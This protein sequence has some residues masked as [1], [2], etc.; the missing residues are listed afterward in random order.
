MYESLDTLKIKEKAGIASAALELKYRKAHRME[1]PLKGLQGA[2]IFLIQTKE[3][4][5]KL[6]ALS[7]LYQKV[8]SDKKVKDIILLDA[9]HSATIEGA[10]TTVENVKR[11][12]D[13]PVSKD[14][15]MV[16]NTI[17]GINYAYENQI[18]MDNIRTL[19]EIITQDVCENVHLAGAQFRSGMV[20]V[21]S[22]TDIIHTPAK[23]EEISTMM[24]DLFA[25]IE[26]SELN[27]WMKAAIIHF[28]FVYIH[29]FCDGN[30][31]TAR[32]MTQSF[33]LHHGIEKIK[34]LP[35]SRTINDSLSSYYA[36]LKESEKVYSNGEKWIDITPFIDYM[37]DTIGMCMVTAVRED[38]EMSESQKILLNK[39]QKRGK[40]AEITIAVAA[41]ILKVSE[42][43]AGRKLNA[44]V[45]IG[46][47]KK[48]KRERRNIYIL[49]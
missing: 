41:K 9:Y 2:V 14:D 19:W 32:I 15:K 21:G 13:K 40:G 1:I 6:A 5:E 42:Q 11:A 46:Y 17:H 48:E 35:L 49:K 39:I 30:G 38:N 34:Y 33:L 18:G 24:Q 3:I 26:H 27:V 45:K 12:Y 28:Y 31:R 7:N 20:Y 44:L 4:E 23:A 8:S 25:F 36:M 22:N 47:L 29:P 16:V 43:T 10:R 37:L